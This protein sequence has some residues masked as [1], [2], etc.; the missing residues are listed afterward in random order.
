MI[1]EGTG[2]SPGPG[3]GSQSSW[4]LGPLFH[5]LSHSLCLPC[6]PSGHFSEPAEPAYLS[7]P[8]SRHSE[9]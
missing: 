3:I 6:P 4:V 7:V 2:S 8:S 1:V 9:L 5:I